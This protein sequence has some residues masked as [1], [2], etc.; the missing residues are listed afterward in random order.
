LNKNRQP[1]HHDSRRIVVTRGKPAQ[2]FARDVLVDIAV[3][4]E[5]KMLPSSSL[6][7]VNA[8]NNCREWIGPVEAVKWRNVM[9]MLKIPA[10]LLFLGAMLVGLPAKAAP[11]APSAA[12]EP[13]AQG[14]SDVVKVHFGGWGGW[15]R[16]ADFPAAAAADALIGATN[17]APYYD[18]GDGDDY[19]YL[20]FPY[21]GYH[22]VYSCHPYCGWGG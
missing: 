16:G 18:G 21:P 11:A 2:L 7:Y 14:G 9:S 13:M 10:A 6:I 22:H 8:S 15:H 5:T 12:T 19:G 20:A 3:V 1:I 4:D 17:T